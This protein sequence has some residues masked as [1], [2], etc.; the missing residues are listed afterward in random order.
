MTTPE[1]PPSV[2]EILSTL[3]VLPH[4]LQA[5]NPA[6]NIH[7]LRSI[8]RKGKGRISGI[9]QALP[10]ADGLSTLA[11][12]H[13]RTAKAYDEAAEQLRTLYPDR[14]VPLTPSET[15]EGEGRDEYIVRLVK[16][17]EPVRAVGR[18]FGLNAQ[19]ALN[20]VRAHEKRTGEKIPRYGKPYVEAETSKTSEEP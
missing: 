11:E 13:R 6:L 9:M 20:I 15:S 16:S 4:K 17:G 2:A 5:A 18:A 10:I 1:A 8:L 7:T 14:R 19:T 3:D 12:E